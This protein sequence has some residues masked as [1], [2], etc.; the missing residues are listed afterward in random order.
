M[1]NLTCE[2]SNPTT[3][4]TFITK[5]TS[6]IEVDLGIL[7]KKVKKESYYIST[8]KQVSVDATISLDMS[9]FNVVE[10]PYEHPTEGEIMLK[11]LHLR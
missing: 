10:R 7:G 11:W 9:L 3:K 5:L 1:K 2:Q 4:G 6:T 8:T